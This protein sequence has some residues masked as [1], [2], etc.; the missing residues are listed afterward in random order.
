MSQAK[1]KPLTFVGTLKFQINLAEAEVVI[2]IMRKE[3]KGLTKGAHR[4][5]LWGSQWPN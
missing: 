2:M 5:M 3:L 4:E 1:Q